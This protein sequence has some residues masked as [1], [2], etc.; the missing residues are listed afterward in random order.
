MRKAVKHAEIYCNLI[1]DYEPENHQNAEARSHQNV[2]MLYE[3]LGQFKEALRHYQ[4]YLKISKRKGDKSSIVQAYGC[5]GSVYAHLGNMQLALTYH[6][7]HISMAKGLGNEKILATAYE[8]LGDTQTLLKKWE[9]AVESYME[10][11]NS[12]PRN[13]IRLQTTA[14]CKLGLAYRKQGRFQYSMYYFEQVL[15]QH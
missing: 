2:G 10:M 11:F 12:C 4:M 1:K 3:I 9:G 6:D 5:L 8:L 14:L 15:C 13:D 7:Q